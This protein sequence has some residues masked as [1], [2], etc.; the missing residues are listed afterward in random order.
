M[1]AVCVR[2]L[3]ARRRALSDPRFL[4]WVADSYGTLANDDIVRLLWSEYGMQNSQGKILALAGAMLQAFFVKSFE[5]VFLGSGPLGDV[6]QGVSLERTQ[7][8]TWHYDRSEVMSP[9]TYRHHL[10]GYLAH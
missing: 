1:A 10:Q 7:W 6:C 2:A 3:S 4:G 5:V 9:D 8:T